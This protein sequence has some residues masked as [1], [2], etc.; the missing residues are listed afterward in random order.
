MKKI[1]IDMTN[2]PHVLFFEPIIKALKGEFEFIITARDHQQTLALLKEKGFT[3]TLVGRHYGKGRIG[4]I[5]G[6]LHRTLALYKFMRKKRKEI[7]FS[8]SHGSPYCTLASKL[9]GI[10]NIW[11]IDHDAES[12]LFFGR[13]ANVVLIPKTANVTAH[14]RYG[15]RKDRIVKYPGL[16]EELYLWAFKPDKRYFGKI[17]FNT[18]KKI[19]LI[20]P[21]ASE[22]IYINKI[23]VLDDLIRKLC[24]RYALILIPRSSEQKAHYSKLFSDS[25]F[26][27][28]KALDG[29]NSI[30]NSDLVISAGGTMNR[31][32]VVL[33]TKALSTYQEKLLSVDSWLIKNG[34]IWHNIAP[35]ADY[36]DKV[37]GSKIKRY[38]PSSKT[39]DFFINFL[40]KF[41]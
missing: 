22:A 20:R 15:V 8:I 30:S 7:A 24:K 27:P 4:K 38:K 13:W 33:G 41:A 9:L 23:N 25:I 32:A 3:Y 35:S 17:G 29:P 10:K 39:L 21:E 14:V 28:P 18:N 40:K 12:N 2:S 26:I 5:T 36:V 1:W 19:I 6:L 11:T 34:Y 37:M 16:K 31:E